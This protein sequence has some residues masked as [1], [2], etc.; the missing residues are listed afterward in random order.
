M[1]LRLDFS[2][3]KGI[4]SYSSSICYYFIFYWIYWFGTGSQNYT[5]FKFIFL[6]HIIRILYYVF[7]TPWLISIN[8]HLSPHTLLHSCPS[9]IPSPAITTILYPWFFHFSFFAQSLHTHTPQPLPHTDS[10]Q[11]LSIFSLILNKLTPDC[12]GKLLQK[13]MNFG[14]TQTLDLTLEVSAYLPTFCMNLFKLLNL[15]EL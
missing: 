3:F 6:Q 15:T 8:H 13:K 7:R 9:S 1:S 2:I 10:C 12:L 11:P 5:D 14:V 4:F